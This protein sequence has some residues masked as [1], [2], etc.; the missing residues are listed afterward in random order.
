[1]MQVAAKMVSSD[2]R[3]VP[4]TPI[5]D[6]GGILI[7]THALVGP[8]P[9]ATVIDQ[10]RA[11]AGTV[12]W[13]PV[14]DVLKTALERCLARHHL[15]IGSRQRLAITKA[16]RNW[17]LAEVSQH[18]V[19][20]PEAGYDLLVACR[21]AILTTLPVA[22]RQLFLDAVTASLR[23][24]RQGFI[25]RRDCPTRLRGWRD[26][27]QARLDAEYEMLAAMLQT[28]H[29]ATQ[30]TDQPATAKNGFDRE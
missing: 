7:L 9:S 4:T 23:Q 21:L 14:G 29:P 15:Q 8:L 22:E 25:V 5:P 10:L 6:F 24:G 13:H 2:D 12:G 19:G 30:S 16:G 20:V 27:A 1:M 11:A 3:P 18:A 17:L 28:Q 26:F